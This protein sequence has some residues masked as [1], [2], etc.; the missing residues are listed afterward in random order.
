MD[1]I[2]GLFALIWI[3]PD[4]KA[5]EDCKWKLFFKSFYA[6]KLFEY[7]NRSVQERRNSIANAMELS[8]SC[9]NPSI[10]PM[11]FIP[12]WL[13]SG[14]V[15]QSVCSCSQHQMGCIILVAIT[16]I[17]ILVPYHTVHQQFM[18]NCSQVECHRTPSMISQHG[19]QVM[20]WYHQATNHYLN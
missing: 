1:S 20:A 5:I 8:L 19:V 12:C 6:G 7:I 14:A 2:D 18:W 13:M 3:Y 17:I 15:K 11:M 10:S 9:T 4:L 16:V